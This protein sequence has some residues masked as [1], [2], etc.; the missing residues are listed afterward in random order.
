MKIDA[1]LGLYRFPLSKIHNH[2]R[3]AWDSSVKRTLSQN[4]RIV[5]KVN[6]V[7]SPH[8]RGVTDRCKN[9]QRELVVFLCSWSAPQVSF[10]IA[11]GATLAPHDTRDRE[12]AALV[13]QIIDSNQTTRN[14][15]WWVDQTRE[16]QVTLFTSG[17]NTLRH[18]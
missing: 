17:V 14:G 7:P 13:V 2:R 3:S 18:W 8:Y 15:L 9:D 12:A 6:P 10:H 1:K 4:C 11:V 16:R 5:F